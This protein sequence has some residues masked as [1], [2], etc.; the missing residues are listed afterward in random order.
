MKKVLAVVL[1]TVLMVSVLLTGLFSITASAA[2]S[3]TIGDCWWSLDGTV[4]TIGGNGAMEDFYLSK[5]APWFRKN[6]TEVIIQKGVTSIGSCAFRA[7]TCITS[8]TIPNTVKTIGIAAFEDCTL[9]KEI[10]YLGTEIEDANILV[11]RN[12]PCLFEANWHNNSCI[13]SIQHAYDDSCDSICNICGNIRTI[14]HAYDGDCNSECNVC[15]N[16]RTAFEHNFGQWAIISMPSCTAKGTEIR[17]CSTCKQEE[18]RDVPETGHALGVWKVTTQ[19]TCENKGKQ[20]KSCSKCSYKE[21]KEIDAT[22][23]SYLNQWTIDTKAT[24][25]TTGSKS[26]HC[27]NC[28][29]KTDLTNIAPTGHSFDDWETTKEPTCTKEGTQSRKCNDCPKIETKTIHANG[30]SYDSNWVIDIKATCTTTGSKS[31]HCSNCNSKTDLTNIAPTSHN[32]GVLSP[33]Y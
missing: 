1:T 9:L 29:S 4:L 16:I 3:G 14:S 22:G 13:G 28:D 25:T 18:T 6:M 2:T 10:Y 30:H 19:P 8:I 15:G 21:T 5:T 33:I 32:F 7:C 26:H 12:N 27:L 31:H 17:T 11:G 23:H 24:C 20:T